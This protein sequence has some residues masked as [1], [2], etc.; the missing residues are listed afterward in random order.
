LLLRFQTVSVLLP[1]RPI[2]AKEK[3]DSAIEQAA[4]A[5]TESR[6]AVQGLRAS[7]LEANDLAQAVNTLGEELAGESA[8]SATIL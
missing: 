5:I 3:L 6:D 4:G 8:D 7:T 2:E 1:E